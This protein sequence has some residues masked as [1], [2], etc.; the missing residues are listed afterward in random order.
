MLNFGVAKS[1]QIPDIKLSHRY[2]LETVSRA[3]SLLRELGAED[4][5]L[6]L[7]EIAERTGF[8][9]TICFRLLRTL[10][11]TGFIRR[12]QSRKYISNVRILDGKRFRIGYASQG[13]DSFSGAVGLGL[14]RAAS[15]ESIDL[16]ELDNENSATS[17]LRNAEAFVRQHVD[18]VIQF[19][20][21]DRIAPKLASLFG[22]A[23][24]PVIAVEIPQ[25][26]ACF[27][28]VDNYKVGTIAGKALLR[29]AQQHWQGESDEV[30]L[31][32]LGVA[33]SI[34]Q[35]RL[36]GSQNVL[37]KGLDASS[38][39]THL[40]SRG[41]FL[42]AFEV[43]RKHLQ[44]VPRQRTLVCGVNDF[45]VL[46]ALRAFEEAGRSKLCLAVGLGGGPEMRRELRLGNASL[47]GAVAFFPENYGKGLMKLAID[48][49]HHNFLPPAH[50]VPVQLITAKNINQ[51][52]PKDIYGS[53][54]SQ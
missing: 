21:H 45:A 39:I 44:L 37:L 16:I 47:I 6:T 18:L 42:R 28:G 38:V 51:F 25:P 43:T 9:R 41:E 36:S 26:D 11:D 54:D 17:A 33:G 10:E 4:H 20:V 30:L 49:L 8:E 24:I 50:Y 53:F 2:K 29:A 14:H 34:P 19:Q 7:N 31:L 15:E 48:T 40:E 1:R 5:A 32:D 46:G 52:Y 23:N 35:L 12:A 3:C 22:A 27:F 13:H